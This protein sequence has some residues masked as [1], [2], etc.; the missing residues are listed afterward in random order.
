MLDERLATRPGVHAYDPL[1]LVVDV[2]GT[3]A[4]G[5]QVARLLHERDIYPEL[6]GENVVVAVFG[7]GETAGDNAARLVTALSRRSPSCP[8]GEDGAER[9]FAPPPPWGPLEMTPREAFLGAQEVVPVEQAVGRIAA[10]SLAAYP[11]GIPNVLPGRA[12]DGGDVG[13]RAGDAR[14]RR[15]PARRERPHAADRARGG[16]GAVSGRPGCIE[17]ADDRVGPGRVLE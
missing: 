7:M 12:A 17:T 13:V 11:P 2:R 16:G 1:R 4:T 15:Q 10:E 6:A 9:E 3:G 8:A 5:Y 14:A